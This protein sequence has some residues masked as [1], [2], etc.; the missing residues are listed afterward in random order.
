[1]N[2]NDMST[3]IEGFKSNAG[4]GL[5][6]L[7]YYLL[8]YGKNIINGLG[9]FKKDVNSV[10]NIRNQIELMSLKLELEQKKKTSGL[11][12]QELTQLEADVMR[13]FAATGSTEFTGKQRFIAIPL[14]ILTTIMAGVEL[15]ALE[16][17]PDTTS[18]DIVLG[19]IFVCT[20]IVV[21]F[22]GI[23]HL[24]KVKSKWGRTTG[25]IFYWTFV[26]YIALTMGFT[27][28]DNA[29]GSTISD[30]FLGVFLLVSLAFCVVAG[31]RQRLP[32]M[33]DSPSSQRSE[34]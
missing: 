23:Q 17:T 18:L 2:I 1:M 3:F 8:V 15:Q 30:D 33:P 7:G 29:I 9:L 16:Q 28:I 12:E 24:N 19:Y 5:L 25:F 10:A 14:L 11:S 21:G 20:M 13:H 6:L 31:V 32:G 22:W 26:F 4:A 34:P 27:I